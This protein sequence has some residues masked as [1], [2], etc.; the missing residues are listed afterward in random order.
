[1]RQKRKTIVNTYLLTALGC[2]AF[3]LI[4]E[5]F[6][7]QVYS[8]FMLGAFAV[9]LAGGAGL[10]AALG[11]KAWPGTLC[12]TMYHSALA[13]L[14]AGCF[15]RGVLDIYGTTNRLGAMYWATGALFA[16]AALGLYV[17]ERTEQA[18]RRE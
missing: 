8:P 7:H 13:A 6:S 17:M 16:V 12:R 10:F 11:P 14:T 9:P 2:L 1:M 15:F 18:G 5:R 4:Y 3:G